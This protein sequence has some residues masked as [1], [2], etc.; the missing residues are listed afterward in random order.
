[1]IR[2]NAKIV[3]FHE[4][5]NADV[6][7]IEE[8]AIPNPIADEITIKVDAI[9]LNRAEVMFREGQYLE[10]PTFPS[11]LGYEVS[12]T[13]EAV[14]AQVTS[15]EVG[16]KVSTIPAF[17]IGKYG[18]YGEFATVPE[19]AVVKYPDNLTAEE[20]TSIWMA[21]LTAY[22]AIIEL[23]KA[24]AKDVILIT[25]ASSS[26]GLASIQIAKT[27]GLVVIATTRTE[28]KKQ[29]LLDAG[30]DYVIVTNEEDLEDSVNIITN[31]KGVDIVFDPVG[32]S[33]LETLANA[34]AHQ[35]IIIEYGALSPE[36]T[37]YPL[38]Q[39]LQKGLSIRGYTLFEI[40]KNPESLAK[41]KEYLFTK[42]EEGA[43]KPIIDTTFSFDKIVDAHKYMESN[44]QKGK[45]VVTV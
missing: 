45:I 23:A 16:D 33:Y 22:G 19:H 4:L 35:G 15:F 24:K 7:K 11:R 32:G 18:V 2:K 43:L 14:G 27:E 28:D 17:S 6:L 41:G 42:F 31:D 12:G 40:T 38:F 10:S 20:G 39:A 30:V 29:F 9:G 1:M 26:V 13:I 8:E 25:A 44:V 3:R 36:A 21:Y 34:T 37:P 5:G